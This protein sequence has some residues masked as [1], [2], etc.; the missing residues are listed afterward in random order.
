[1][2]SNEIREHF[3]GYVNA[4]WASSYCA[5]EQVLP[6]K[7]SGSKGMYIKA[8]TEHF[9]TMEKLL[10]FALYDENNNLLL[11]DK[12]ADSNTNPETSLKNI[13]NKWIDLEDPDFFLSVFNSPAY[14]QTAI[15]LGIV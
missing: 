5:L 8:I 15:R 3:Y 10:G 1:M 9:Y 6:R 2:I 14:Q 13:V 4:V 11:E 7:S 12:Y